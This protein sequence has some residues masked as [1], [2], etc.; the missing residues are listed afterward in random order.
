L[1]TSWCPEMHG[2]EFLKK[3]KAG[4][5]AMERAKRVKRC[6][7]GKG[8]CETRK[9]ILRGKKTER[10]KTEKGKWLIQAVRERKNGSIYSSR[11]ESLFGRCDDVL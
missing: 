1:W 10:A 7:G 9:N 8:E 11:L 3:R 2:V 6:E 4:C 5:Q